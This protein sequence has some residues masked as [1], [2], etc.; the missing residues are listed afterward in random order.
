MWGRARGL[1]LSHNF[2]A[3]PPPPAPGQDSPVPASTP[4]REVT[5]RTVA[6]SVKPSAASSVAVLRS[7]PAR[8]P[9]ELPSQRVAPRSMR[10]GLP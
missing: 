3:S 1:C 8:A 6:R 9:L 2:D 7:T 5:K 4:A 10:P